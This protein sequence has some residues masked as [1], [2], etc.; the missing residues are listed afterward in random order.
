MDT[1]QWAKEGNWGPNV[2]N[3]LRQSYD[4]IMIM[5][6]LQSTYDR[7]LVYKISHEER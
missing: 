5:P 1:L 2:Q 4:Y 6:K 7:R 3:I